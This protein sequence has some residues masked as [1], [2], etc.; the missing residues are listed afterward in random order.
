MDKQVNKQNPLRAQAAHRGVPVNCEQCGRRA[1]R[2]PRTQLYCS[3]LC[4]KRAHRGKTPTDALKNVARYPQRDIPAETSNDLNSLQAVISGSSHYAKAPFNLFGGGQ[5]QLPGATPPDAELRQKFFMPRS[6]ASSSRLARMGRDKHEKERRSGEGGFVMLLTSTLDSPAWRAMSLGARLLYVSVRRRSSK[7]TQN[8]GRIFL[9]QRKAAIELRTHH[10]QIARW[11]REPALRFHCH[12][13]AGLSGRRWQRQGTTLAADRA[14]LHEGRA[15]PGLYELRRQEVHGRKIRTHAG[16][17]ARGVP[18][19][20]HGGV[21][22]S[23]PLDDES[24]PGSQHIGKPESVPGSQ[25][26]SLYY[27]L[28]IPFLPV[29]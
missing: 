29:L 9:S 28:P 10:N 19:S 20:Q 16:K 14:G 18:G 7:N 2:A 8:N 6:A 15:H 12:V 11:F 22:E 26:I 13:V 5:L 24:V 4:R 3:T 21:L 1:K 17:S 25:H 27:H 23:R